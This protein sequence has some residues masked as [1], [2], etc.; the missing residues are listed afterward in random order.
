MVDGCLD[1]CYLP[2]AGLRVKTK[3]AMKE[4]IVSQPAESGRAYAEHT[5]WVDGIRER[6]RSESDRRKRHASR[7]SVWQSGES[8]R[9]HD[10]H[11]DGC[12]G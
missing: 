10:D 2:D 3:T 5:G 9:D 4:G 12:G 7:I 8:N 11:G 1:S 6:I